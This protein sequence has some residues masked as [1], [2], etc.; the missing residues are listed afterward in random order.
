MRFLDTTPTPTGIFQK[1]S[2][3]GSVNHFTKAASTAATNSSKRIYE[4]TSTVVASNPTLQAAAAGTAAGVNYKIED[5]S[6]TIANVE[7]DADEAA[8][9]ESL[10]GSHFKFNIK[11]SQKNIRINTEQY[12]SK[13]ESPPLSEIKENYSS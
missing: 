13:I 6:D 9:L 2:G 10:N 4:S 8:N 7:E 3:F 11:G 12:F 1:Y 5:V